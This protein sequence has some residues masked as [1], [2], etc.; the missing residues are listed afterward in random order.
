MNTF[1]SFH[2]LFLLGQGGIARVYKAWCLR[3]Q[4]IVALK[5]FYCGLPQDGFTAAVFRREAWLTGLLRHPHIVEVYESGQVDDYAYIAMQYCPRGSLADALRSRRVALS[6]PLAVSVVQQIGA[7]LHY[8]HNQSIIHADVKPSNILFDEDGHAL[9]SDF[10]IAQLT[11]TPAFGGTP[12]YA[13]P[14]QAAGYPVDH[15]TDVYGL[16]AVVV[17]MLAGEDALL[18]FN[19][20]SIP[21]PPGVPARIREILACAMARDPS[22]RLPSIMD[23][24]ARLTSC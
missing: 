20:W 10:S 8:A 3:R 13:A 11:R 17:A 12:G 4:A 16:A 23:L 15:R 5:V 1:G 9:L 22:R 14:E 24:V 21:L 6:W 2:L 18:G 19:A 7:A